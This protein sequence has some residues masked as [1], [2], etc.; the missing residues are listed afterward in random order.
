MDD[1]LFDVIPPSLRIAPLHDPFP[2]LISSSA[3]PSP[4]EPNAHITTDNDANKL[5]GRRKALAQAK[6]LDAPEPEEWDPRSTSAMNDADCAEEDSRKKQ[7]RESRD[8]EQTSEFVQLPRPSAKINLDKPR[9]FPPLS[10][11]NELHE[12]PPSVALFPPITP[13]AT[14]GGEEGLLSRP[15]SPRANI[16]RCQGHSRSRKSNERPK[17]PSTTTRTYNRGRT[18]W[19]QDEIDNLIKGVT[20]YGTGRWKN[21]LEHPNLHFKEGRTPTDL[22]DR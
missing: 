22:K 10:I 6:A 5:T 9:P 19:S 7:K 16:D 1:F 21:V 2:T 8:A 4:L 12:P 14:Q 17:S 13:N 11:L 15:D 18:K 20:I 3:R